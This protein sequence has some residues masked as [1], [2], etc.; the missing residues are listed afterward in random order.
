MK[1]KRRKNNLKCDAKLISF[2]NTK[3]VFT[4]YVLSPHFSIPYFCIKFIFMVR[5]SQQNL[6]QILMVAISNGF[7]Q[8]LKSNAKTIEIYKVAKI[9]RYL[10]RKREIFSQKI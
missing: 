5:K 6:I 2:Y 8:T 9:V 4:N 3:N 1:R 10:V 7:V